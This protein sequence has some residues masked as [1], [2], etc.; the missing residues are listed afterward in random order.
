MAEALHRHP[1]EPSPRSAFFAEHA[2]S[3]HAPAWTESG[4][5]E[6]GGC[7]ESYPGAEPEPEAG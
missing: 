4:G 2:E 6:C 1:E 7:G 3:G 5:V